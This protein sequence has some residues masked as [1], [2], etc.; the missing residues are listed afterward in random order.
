[1][2]LGIVPDAFK[3]LSMESVSNHPSVVLT[4]FGVHGLG[5]RLSVFIRLTYTD[6]YI[7]HNQW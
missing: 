7:L 5:I 6:T 3:Y 4:A 1:M 2:A